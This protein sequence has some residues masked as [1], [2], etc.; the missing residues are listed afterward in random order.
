M[1]KHTSVVTTGETAISRHSLRSG[2]N[3]FL[4]ALPGDRALLPPSP[5]DT[6][7]KLDASVGA[8]GPHDF[9]VRVS[10]A[11][12]ASQPASTAS[13]TNVRDDRDTPLLRVRDVRIDKAVSTKPRS[14]IFFQRELDLGISKQPDGQ[15]SEC[16]LRK[17]PTMCTSRRMTTTVA[18]YPNCHGAACT[19][20]QD[21]HV[22]IA[23]NDF[24]R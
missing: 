17:L 21:T 7:A 11:R 13:R 12:L 8:S 6:S 19:P 10:V 23:P 20:S 24:I 16:G 1:K 4:R 18:A 3:G 14:E 2:F 9:A 5:A 15:I 22:N